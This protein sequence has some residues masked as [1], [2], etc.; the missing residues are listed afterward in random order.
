MYHV[1]HVGTLSGNFQDAH[2][3][4]TVVDMDAA[5]GK[6]AVLTK[7]ELISNEYIDEGLAAVKHAD[8]VSWWLFMHENG[9]TGQNPCS[10][11]FS[12]F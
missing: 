8:G 10:Q 7:N 9:G 11:N 2:L 4:H 1:F 6:G 5:G 3:F 12:G